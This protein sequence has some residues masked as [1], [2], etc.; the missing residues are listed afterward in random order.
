MVTLCVPNSTRRSGVKQW[1]VFS[2][3]HVAFSVVR[4]VFSVVQV[5]FGEF[6]D[7][8]SAYPLSHVAARVAVIDWISLTKSHQI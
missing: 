7:T 4:V 2:V 6:N 5:V 8:Y 3:V 1:V